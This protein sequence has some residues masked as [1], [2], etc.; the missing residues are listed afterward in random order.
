MSTKRHDDAFW[1]VGELRPQFPEGIDELNLAYDAVFP[2]GAIL[3][4]RI[5]RTITEFKGRIEL[6]TSDGYYWFSALV[7]KRGGGQIAVAF[8]WAQDW[9]KTDGVQ[10]DRSIAFYA[11]EQVAEVHLRKLLDQ[12]VA[13]FK[14]L[15]E[16]LAAERATA[17]TTS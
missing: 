3:E 17:E 2:S 4:K 15:A 13:R 5:G 12:L 16:E 11:K 9:A 10:N 7:F 8:P 1:G 6:T 14:K